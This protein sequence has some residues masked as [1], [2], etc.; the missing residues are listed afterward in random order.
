LIGYIFRGESYSAQRKLNNFLESIKENKR[1]IEILNKSIQT[2][3]QI[4]SREIPDLEE[5]IT[6]SFLSDPKV[7]QIPF[8][9]Y[10]GSKP[11]IFV[12]Y[13][14]SDKL[15]VYPIMD[16][17]NKSG[18]NIWY[19]EGI[20]VSENWKQSIVENLNRCS[21]F[22]VFITPNIIDSEY[23]RKEIDYALSRKKPFYSVYLKDTKL[24]DELEFD[25]A[26]IQSMR[27]N[28]MQDDEFYEKLKED[29]S[30]VL[31]MR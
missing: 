20:S 17:L 19:D 26:N 7:F 24:P 12:S 8:K 10:K 28:V 6:K 29:L 14:H 23:V 5:L 30:P 3:K 27:K 15:H 16:F 4:L 22:L 25:I 13:A 9:A 1:F 2:G 21:A 18:F 11:F 31:N